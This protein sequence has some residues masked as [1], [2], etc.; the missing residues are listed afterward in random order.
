MSSNY[1]PDEIRSILLNIT[2]DADVFKYGN[3]IIPE[4][5]RL[6]VLPDETVLAPPCDDT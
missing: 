2:S 6:G 4:F 3:S 5:K 1:S